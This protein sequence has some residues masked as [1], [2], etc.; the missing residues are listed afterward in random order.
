M[1]DEKK[2]D[3]CP[4]IVGKP[5]ACEMS[6]RLDEYYRQMKERHDRPQVLFVGRFGNCLC[7]PD[8]CPRYLEKMKDIKQK[9]K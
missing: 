4:Y 7:S 2:V 8:L 6:Y 3:F 9:Q 1:A 5:L